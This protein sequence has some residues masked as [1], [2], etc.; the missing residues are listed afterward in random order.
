MGGRTSQLA[1][2]FF[3]TRNEPL[4]VPS[5]VV[6]TTEPLPIGVPAAT[7]AVIDVLEPATFVA[8]TPE[9]VTLGSVLL[10]PRRFVPLIV[11]VVPAGPLEGDTDVIV[12]DVGGGVVV[13]LKLDELVAV[14]PGVVTAIWP[15][16][17]PDGTTATT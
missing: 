14:P 9:N 6:T 16:V 5:F 7:R 10:E 8:A 17:A 12:G 2:Y 15:L 13:T 1:D 11:T 4:A 3:E